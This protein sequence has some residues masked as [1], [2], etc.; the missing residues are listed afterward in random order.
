[1]K[2]L[3]SQDNTFPLF[4]VNYCNNGGNKNINYGNCTAISINCFKQ[5]M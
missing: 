3:T 4:V 5:K 1:M 2:I